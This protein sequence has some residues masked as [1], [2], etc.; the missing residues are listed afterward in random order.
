MSEVLHAI[1]V[2]KKRNFRFSV[3]LGVIS[4]AISL[5]LYLSRALVSEDMQ[6]RLMMLLVLSLVMGNVSL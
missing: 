5:V 3:A 6:T 2:L 1:S 4:L